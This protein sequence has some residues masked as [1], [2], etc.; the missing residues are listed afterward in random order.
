MLLNTVYKIMTSIVRKLEAY[1]ERRISEYQHEFR[2]GKSTVQAYR[3]YVNNSGS[4]I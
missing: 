2:N 1:T 4:M 3:K